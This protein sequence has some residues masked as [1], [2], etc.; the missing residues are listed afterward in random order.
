MKKLILP[1]FAVLISIIFSLPVSAK[2]PYE[3]KLDCPKISSILNFTEGGGASYPCFSFEDNAKV[4]TTVVNLG[5]WIDIGLPEDM[6]DPYVPSQGMIAVKTDELFIG[7]VGKIFYLGPPWGEG[8]PRPYVEYSARLGLCDIRLTGTAHYDYKVE[9]YGKQPDWQAASKYIVEKLSVAIKEV[10]SSIADECGAKNITGSKNNTQK[11]EPRQ[12]QS[13]D[14]ENLFIKALGGFPVT[15]GEW[16]KAVS[17][18]WGLKEFFYQT[19]LFADEVLFGRDKREI[20]EEEA[21]EQKKDRIKAQ[22]WRDEFFDKQGLADLDEVFNRVPVI[23]DTPDYKSGGWQQDSPFR[24]DILNGQAQIKYPGENEWRDVKVGDKIPPGSTIFTGMDTTTV[25]SIKDKGVVQ[26]QSFT[27][28]TISERGLEEAA[29]TGQTYTDIELKTGEIE[30]NIESG[31][32]TAPILQV[33]TTNVVAGVR[34]TRFWVSYNKD[35]NLSTVGVYEGEIEVKARGSDKSTLVSP[36]GDKP[37]VVMVS[38]KLS[39]WKLVLAGLALTGVIG[40]VIFFLK[41]KSMKIS[42]RQKVKRK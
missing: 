27:E 12:P 3:V 4:S 14:K 35:K 10:E 20:A 2:E 23:K 28:I 16:F 39:V 40:G 37:G 33:F 9:G 34:G 19:E 13:E 42:T 38:Q 41:R 36:N 6:A 30:V 7:D 11:T 32:Y 15:I 26:V 24:L 21:A 1:I 25:L 5:G 18:G 17:T 22:Q 29:K 8:F 31:V